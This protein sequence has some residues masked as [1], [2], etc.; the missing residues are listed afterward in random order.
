MAYAM[1]VMLQNYVPEFVGCWIFCCS[2]WELNMFPSSL[3]VL[4]HV[5]KFS[6]VH[7]QVTQILNVFPDMFPIA[8]HFI[9]Y[10]WPYVLL[11]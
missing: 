8:S 11:L 1:H 10:P 9:P 2:H 7:Q 6:C 5:L 3:C 4:Q